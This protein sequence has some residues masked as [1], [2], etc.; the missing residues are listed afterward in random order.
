MDSRYDYTR[1]YSYSHMLFTV[2]VFSIFPNCEFSFF[3]LVSPWIFLINVD[4]G[5]QS[6]DT[7]SLSL[8]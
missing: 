5:K 2:G 3:L 1:T 7:A 6:H 4:F 8:N